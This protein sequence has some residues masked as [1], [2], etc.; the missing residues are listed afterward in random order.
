MV[1]QEFKR[2]FSRD[3]RSGA[4]GEDSDYSKNKP[5]FDTRRQCQDLQGISGEGT[6]RSDVQPAVEHGRGWAPDYR[7]DTLPKGI[8]PVS[9]IVLVADGSSGN[10][11]L[12]AL[13]ADTFKEVF[14]LW[15][16]R[17]K[18]YGPGNIAAFGELGCVV[19]GFDKMARLRHTLIEDP[20]RGGLTYDESI[21]DSWKDLTNY[22]V[23]GLVCH[24]KQ[25]PSA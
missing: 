5:T 23:M 20:D 1:S 2:T 7:L 21:E 10:I 8:V 11:K 9:D 14:N 12:E 22:A 17:Q 15:K 13:V 4:G 19:R 24:R 18:K 6:P 25:W 16:S 3:P